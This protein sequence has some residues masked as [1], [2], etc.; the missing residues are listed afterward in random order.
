LMSGWDRVE[1][2][3]CVEDAVRSVLAKW[4]GDHRDDMG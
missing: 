1:A 4:Q 3:L 2:R